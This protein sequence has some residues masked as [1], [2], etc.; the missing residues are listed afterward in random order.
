[1]PVDLRLCIL[2]EEPLGVLAAHAHVLAPFSDIPEVRGRP[3][4]RRLDLGADRSVELDVL[5]CVVEQHFGPVR[6]LL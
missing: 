3:A 1:M 6:C 5:V 4:R 2:F